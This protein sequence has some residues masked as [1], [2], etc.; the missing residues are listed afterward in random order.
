MPPPATDFY[1]ILF[2][3]ALLLKTNMEPEVIHFTFFRQPPN[4]EKHLNEREHLFVLWRHLHAFY[5]FDDMRF[6][7]DPPDFVFDYRDKKIGAELTL[8]NPKTFPEGGYVERGK[9]TEWKAKPKLDANRQ[10][11]PW[12]TYSLR[13]SL[14]AFK[15]QLESKR[16]KAHQWATAFPER[17]LL[18][19][20]DGGSPFA[21]VAGGIPRV[22]PGREE[23]YADYVAK[24]AHGLHSICQEINPFDYVIL[25]TVESFAAFP[26]SPINSHKFPRL[27]DDILERGAHASDEFLEW[28]TTIKSVSQPLSIGQNAPKILP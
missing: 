15:A 25:F 10:E 7:H 28:T 8:L 17:W 24:A 6:G 1:L 23:E 22:K 18:M 9:F 12:G 2:R 4:D 3:W 26:A 21:D 11:F 14:A 20:I 5:K 16:Q 19:R 27:R 13:D